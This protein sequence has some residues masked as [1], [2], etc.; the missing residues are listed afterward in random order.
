[1]ILTLEGDFYLIENIST[2]A[3]K[4]RSCLPV[5]SMNNWQSH[6]CSLISMLRQTHVVI[7]LL[8]DE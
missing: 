7:G 5:K 4:Y 3:C 6:L 2:E 1:M 8:L